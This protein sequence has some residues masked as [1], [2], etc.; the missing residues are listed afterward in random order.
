MDIIT[1]R[2]ILGIDYDECL[3]LECLKKKYRKMALQHHPDKNGNSADSTERFKLIVEAYECLQGEIDTQ[4]PSISVPTSDD[5]NSDYI[6][7][8]QVFIESMMHQHSQNIISIIKEIVINGCKKISMRLFE[9]M[10][11]DR[12]IS[13]YTF[14]STYKHILHI[15]NET[16]DLV[17]EMILEKYKNDQIYILNPSLDDL[18]EN[19]VYKL[20]IGDSVYLVPLWHNEVY[21]DGSGG[22]GD[23]IV[24]CIPDLPENMS[25]DENNVLHIEHEV[26]FSLSLLDSQTIPFVLGKETLWFTVKFKKIQTHFMAGYGVSEIDDNNMYNVNPK[27]GVNIKVRFI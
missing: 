9:N 16:L 17:K 22:D 10:D 26:P 5:S 25:I 1:A 12:S 24:R 6:H 20:S 8:L 19:N 3:T 13:V 14:L 2:E 15:D 21:F 7:I 4:P 23:I 11:K 27:G 18:L